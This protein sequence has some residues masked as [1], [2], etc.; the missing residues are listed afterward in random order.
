MADETKPAHIS[1]PSDVLRTLLDLREEFP[2]FRQLLG[3]IIRTVMVLD[4]SAIQRELRWRLGSRTNPT[5]RTCLHEAIDSGVVIAFAPFFLKQEIEKYLPSIAS[6]TGV[7]LETATAEWQ[8]VQS[9][10]RFYAP[11]GDGTKF[12]VV[13]PKDSDYA[14]TAAELGADFVRTTDLDF[15]R[16]GVPNIGPE[17]DPVLRDYARATSILV[18]VKLGSG[19]A[20]TFGIHAFIEMIRGVAEIIRQLP[21]V[22]RLI[23]VVGVAFVLLRPTSREKLIQWAKGLCQRLQETKPVLVSI[24]REAVKHLAEAA[25]TSRTTCEVIKSRLPVRGKQTALS[26][27]RLVCLRTEEPLAVDEIA[28]RVLVSGYVSRSKTFT[29]YVRR[30]LMRDGRFVANAEGLWMLRAAA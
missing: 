4:A 11:T 7:T 22:A 30:L 17:L 20:V 29:A 27:V 16:M 24:S 2:F 14:L 19:F 25:R 21:P 10:I 28:R 23:I 9:L 3:D 1:I 15:S 6:K 5:A 13:D 12:A 18:T 26:Y 8:R